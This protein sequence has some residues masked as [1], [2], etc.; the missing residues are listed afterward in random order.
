[1]TYDQLL[2]IIWLVNQKISSVLLVSK[3]LI[4][5]ERKTW[6]KVTGNYVFVYFVV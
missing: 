2:L 4:Y 6:M 3:P 5:R 1:M